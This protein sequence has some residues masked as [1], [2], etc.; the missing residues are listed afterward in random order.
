MGICSAKKRE[1]GDKLKAKVR[2]K[3]KR[4]NQPSHIALNQGNINQDYKL[5]YPPLGQ[6]A[7]GEVRKA[8]HLKSK[9]QRA[10]KILIKDNADP[11]EIV[12]IK[13]EVSEF[14]FQEKKT[15]EIVFGFFNKIQIS[16]FSFFNYFPDLDFEQVGSPE[17]SQG[18]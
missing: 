12:Q 4:K 14:K 13:E 10:V 18:L 1:I 11:H 17:Y 9:L 15:R 6:G 3:S 8:I 2:K 5:L 7:F 16:N